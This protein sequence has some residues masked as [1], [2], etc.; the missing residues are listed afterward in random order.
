MPLRYLTLATFALFAGCDAGYDP[1]QE[2]D[3]EPVEQC[4]GLEPFEG[5]PL[6][7]LRWRFEVSGTTG[8]D[9]S[10]SYGSEGSSTSVDGAIPASYSVEGEIAS[11]VFQKREEHGTLTVRLLNQQEQ[12][13]R[14]E[15]CGDLDFRDLDWIEVESAT[16]SA[17]FGVVTVS[18][19]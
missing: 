11:G 14:A 15:P 12:L 17:D 7:S 2:P 8:L 6:N 16:T 3:P 1:L 4:E 10:G 13:Y 19:S 18:G 5:D 9:F